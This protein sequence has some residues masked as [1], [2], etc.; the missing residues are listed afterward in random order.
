MNKNLTFTLAYNLVSEVAD[1]LERLYKQNSNLHHLIVDCG[2][3]L[4]TD[5]VPD[6]IEKAKER[7]TDALIALSEKYNCDYLKIE[8]QGVSQNWNQIIEY[9]NPDETD[10]VIC[11]DADEQPTERDWVNAI[12]HV[13]RA[14]ESAGYCASLLIDAK[15]ILDK[16]I[17]IVKVGAHFVYDMKSASINY[18]LVGIKASFIKKIGGIPVPGDM[19][20]YGGLEAMLLQKLRQHNMKWYILRDFT[21]VHTNNCKLY[22]EWKDNVIFEQAQKGLP[23]TTFEKW[24]EMKTVVA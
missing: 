8:N 24:L 14:D 5:E 17:P 4:E 11:A 13:L 6:D 9:L 19:Q 7:N 2:F 20:V 21:E 10:I 15:P 18:G 23:Q 12:C 16:N 1:S 3:P 22:R